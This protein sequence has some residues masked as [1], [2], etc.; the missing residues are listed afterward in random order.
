VERIMTA[1]N[2]NWRSLTADPA[3][4]GIEDQTVRSLRK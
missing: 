3:S 4:I 2:P 1:E